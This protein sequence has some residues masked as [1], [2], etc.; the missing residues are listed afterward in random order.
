MNAA[1]VAAPTVMTAAVRTPDMMAALGAAALI[2]IPLGLA[3]ERRRRASEAAL[4]VLG[5]VQTIP[6]IALLAWE[7]TRTSPTRTSPRSGRT[8]PLKQRS[9][10]VLP[11]PLSPTRATARAAG[12]STDAPFSAVVTPKRCD[13]SCAES[14]TGM[15]T[16]VRGHYGWIKAT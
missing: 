10:V 15:G 16:I 2:G 3:L 4:G 14:D 12:T 7:F 1:S 9:I 6:S 11:E 8:R 5:V 13:T